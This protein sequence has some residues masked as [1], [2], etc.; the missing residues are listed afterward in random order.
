[1]F[2]NSMKIA[3]GVVMSAA[4]GWGGAATMSVAGG[5]PISKRRRS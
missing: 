1:M 2:N 3:A 4:I 5:H